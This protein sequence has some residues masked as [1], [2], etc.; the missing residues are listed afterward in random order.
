MRECCSPQGIASWA[1][2]GLALRWAIRVRPKT[3]VAPA[4]RPSRHAMSPFCH[5]IPLRTVVRWAPRWSIIVGHAR[6][7]Q[8]GTDRNSQTASVRRQSSFPPLAQPCPITLLPATGVLGGGSCWT[9][10]D[11]EG[12]ALCSPSFVPRFPARAQNNS[13]KAAKRSFVA[14]VIVDNCSFSRPS[15]SVSV[16]IR[17]SNA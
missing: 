5:S 6:P 2:V 16:P 10:P 12:V 4:Q 17:S 15:R 8:Q 13:S 1:T 11:E 14:F 9:A 7:L 3:L